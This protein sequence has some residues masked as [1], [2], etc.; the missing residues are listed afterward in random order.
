MK[1]DF[2]STNYYFDDETHSMDAFVLNKC[3]E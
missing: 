2:L 1:T 3:D